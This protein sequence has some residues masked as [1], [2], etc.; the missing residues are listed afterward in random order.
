M[1]YY[2]IC[3]NYTRALHSDSE[4]LWN[5]KEL[6][7]KYDKIKQT[8]E[9]ILKIADKSNTSDLEDQLKGKSADE[10]MELILKYQ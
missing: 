1:A 4:R 10:A 3:N 5:T 9:A 6:V 8:A 2:T 7:K